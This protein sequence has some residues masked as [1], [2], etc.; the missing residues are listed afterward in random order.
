MK[1][2]VAVHS[3]NRLWRTRHVAR[4]DRFVGSPTDQ[5]AVT[6]ETPG[7]LGDDR[8]ATNQRPGSD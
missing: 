3:S 8:D 1:K 5:E 7:L 4:L 6:W 2:L